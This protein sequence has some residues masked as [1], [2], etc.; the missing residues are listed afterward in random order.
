M[1]SLI[2]LSKFQFKDT[3]Y[4]NNRA[5]DYLKSKARIP[6]NTNVAKNVIMFIGD[7]MSVPTLMAARTYLGQLSGYTGEEHA[8]HWEKFPYSGFS[9]VI[10][11][12]L[13]F[14]KILANKLFVIR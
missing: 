14:E 7:G 9:K 6:Q 13:F 11:Y 5:S 10:R 8:L 3:V 4:W 1:F 2:V 12:S